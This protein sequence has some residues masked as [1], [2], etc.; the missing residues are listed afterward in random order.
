M[1][2]IFDFYVEDNRTIKFKLSEPIMLEDNGVSEWRFH[3]PNI[4]NGLDATGWAWWLVYVNAKNEKYTIPLTLEYDYDRPDAY[5]IATYTVD[6]GMSCKAGTITFSIEAIDAEVGGEILHEWHTRTYSSVKVENTLQG[7]QVE[8]A[9]TE[10]DI[11][12]ALIVELQ[13]KTAALFAEI[14]RRTDSLVGGATPFPV[15]SVSAMTDITKVYLNTTDKNWYYYNGSAWASGGQYASGIVIDPTLSQ[16]GQAAD[17]KAIDYYKTANDPY[18]LKTSETLGYI[19]VDGSINDTTDVGREVYTD[20]IPVEYGTSMRF[21]CYCTRGTAYVMWSKLALYD[22]EKEFIRRVDLFYDSA[23]EKKVDWKNTDSDVAYVRLTYRTGV[24]SADQ[25]VFTYITNLVAKT[26]GDKIEDLKSDLSIVADTTEMLATTTDYVL[27]LKNNS[28]YGD[29]GDCLFSVRAGESVSGYTRNDGS[30]VYPM[31]N[32]G[33][34]PSS[35][36]PREELTDV[37]KSYVGI[38]TLQ[39]GNTETMYDSTCSNQIDCSTFVTAILNRIPYENSRYTLGTSAS[40]KVGT[41]VGDTLLR[42]SSARGWVRLLTHQMAQWFAEHK[43]LFEIPS[44]AKKAC[45]ILRFGDILFSGNGNHDVNYYGIDHCLFVLGTNPDSGVVMVAQG[46]TAG[47]PTYYDN[48]STVCKTSIVYLTSQYIGNNYKVFA[49]PNYGNSEIKSDNTLMRF[50]MD[51]VYQFEPF[52][53]TNFYITP[54]DGSLSYAKTYAGT[55][56]MYEVMPQRTIK[57]TGATQSDG[58]NYTAYCIEYDKDKNFVKYRNLTTGDDVLDASTKYVRFSF[59]HAASLN[60]N[61][62]LAKLSDFKVVM[63]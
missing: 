20:Y 58:V 40:N 43:R 15:A 39:Y 62:T 46:G 55:P 19:G 52:L 1:A 13:T 50:A 54:A 51:Q 14:Q 25:Y 47:S 8:Y 42:Y 7:N 38:S 34:L 36:A 61:M 57:Y 41:F 49:R 26:L 60:T 48:E 3:I 33:V 12:S 31:A 63:R 59:G 24:L 16:P 44:N 28:A 23:I 53:L 37:I 22:A 35:N 10:S 2:E 21:F 4:V 5:S 17:A 11:I 32:Q 56:E 27:V 18:V 29:G 9:E 45:S 30:V 6:Y